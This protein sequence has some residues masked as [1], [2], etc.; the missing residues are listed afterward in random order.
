MTLL[1]FAFRN[2]YNDALKKTSSEDNDGEEETPPAK[3]SS[4]SS[5]FF[6]DARASDDTRDEPV[7]FYYTPFVCV[8]S[9]EQK[10]LRVM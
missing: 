7:C 1:S 2:E 4:S 5:S 10:K 6:F 3:S 9:K 8:I